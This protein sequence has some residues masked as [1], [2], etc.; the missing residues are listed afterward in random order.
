[1]KKTII[2]ILAFLV[3][4]AAN[5]QDHNRDWANFNRYN[6]ANETVQAKPRAVFMGDSITDNW[7]RMDSDFFNDN[8][9]VGRGISGQTTSHMLVRFRRDVIDHSP[10]YVVILA[11][12]NDIALN[13]G[14]IA[15][16]NILG[17]INSMCEIARANKIKPV[18]CSV[19]PADRIGWRPAVE[20][21]AEEVLKLN[22]M[23][24][25]YAKSEKIQYVDYHSALKDEN[26]GLPAKYASD[27][28]HPNT[29]C[30]KIMEQIILQYL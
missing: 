17:N 15:L 14:Y 16:E 30:Y 19:L 20:K 6:Q 24:K 8:N 11:G 5:A 13:N 12:I 4:F 3:A 1:M 29:D 25:A 23:L 27:G 22:E 28:V 10:K 7:F 18:I 9:L 26:N 21:P 2:S